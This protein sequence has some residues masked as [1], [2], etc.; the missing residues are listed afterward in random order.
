[1]LMCDDSVQF[2]AVVIYSMCVNR[3]TPGILQLPGR[4]TMQRM[5]ILLRL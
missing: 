3:N 5:I 1:M 4:D 2:V